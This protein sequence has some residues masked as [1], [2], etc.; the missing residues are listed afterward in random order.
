MLILPPISDLT[1]AAELKG[2]LQAAVAAGEGLEI[3]ASEV[4]RIST[5]CV[6]V[7]V[8]GAR[9]FAE[10]GGPGLRFARASAAFSDTVTG[11]ALCKALGFPETQ[12]V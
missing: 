4:Q 11:L 7:L 6:Q 9:A 5:P 1:Y 10:A 12:N 8:A 2:H 3:D